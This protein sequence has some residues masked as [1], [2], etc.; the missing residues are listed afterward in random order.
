[1]IHALV[2]GLHA[3]LGS[4][5][6]LR[7]AKGPQRV[8]S[9]PSPALLARRGRG[10]ASLSDT[11]SAAGQ[12]QGAAV[13]AAADEDADGDVWAGEWELGSP[14]TASVGAGGKSHFAP[15]GKS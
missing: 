1:M 4:E 5:R 7:E 12:A 2:G 9:R 10:P 14:G 6:S 13:H 15:T 8:A 3:S 11:R